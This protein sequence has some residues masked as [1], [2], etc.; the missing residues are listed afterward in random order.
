M[1]LS[2]IFDMSLA[3]Y[4]YVSFLDASYNYRVF[5]EFSPVKGSEPLDI[6]IVEKEWEF[7]MDIK[8]IKKIRGWAGIVHN[9]NGGNCCRR[10]I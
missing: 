3:N 7:S 8:P 6:G 10:G 4:F 1:Y 5:L 2:N 9:T